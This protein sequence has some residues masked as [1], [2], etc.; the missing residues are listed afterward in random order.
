MNPHACPGQS[1]EDERLIE[2]IL[3][4]LPEENP[5][6]HQLLALMAIQSDRS[7]E[8]AAVTLENRPRL[9]INPD[10]VQRHCQTRERLA[11]LVMHELLHVML[12]HTRW[13]GPVDWIHNLAFDALINAQLCQLFPEPAWTALFRGL[14]RADELPYAWLRPPSGWGEGQPRWSLQ[15]QALQVHRQLYSSSQLPLTDLLEAIR[16]LCPTVEVLLLGGHGD[17]GD[18]PCRI[19]PELQQ[20]LDD[21]TQSFFQPSRSTDSRHCRY[22]IQPAGQ[23]ARF[24]ERLWQA[25]QPL[26]QDQAGQAQWRPQVQ[27]TRLP[28]LSRRDRRAWLGRILGQPFLLQVQPLEQS[29]PEG[30]HVHVYLDASGSMEAWLPACY[31]LL[32]GVK[33][34]L[35]P[36]IHLFSMQV[37]DVSLE[38]LDTGLVETWLGTDINCV[39][40]HM[41]EHDVKR[42]LVITD[43]YVGGVNTEWRQPLRQG[44]KVHVLLTE[45]GQQDFLR[46][47]GARV[48]ELEPKRSREWQ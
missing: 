3:Q 14:Y 38:Q 31:S 11:M 10:F 44:R 7:V 43:G 47:M 12:G 39:A 28:G 19:D 21:I 35:Y 5:A 46:D 34:A 18:K 16:A 25:L 29:R 26:L 36:Q 9:S 45:E 23:V 27:E 20:A 4:A 33:A 17:G 13:K 24:R 48:Y 1:P 32:S 41:L 15:G 22:R 8:T 2:R 30:G 42:A 6:F 37:T 40:R